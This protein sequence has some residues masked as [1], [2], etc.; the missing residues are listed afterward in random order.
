MNLRS[1]NRRLLLP[2]LV[3][4]Q[5]PRFHIPRHPQFPRPTLHIVIVQAIRSQSQR[6]SGQKLPHPGPGFRECRLHHSRGRVPDLVTAGRI[7]SPRHLRPEARAGRVLRQ[8][9][10]HRT[11]AAAPRLQ[12]RDGDR[13]H[14]RDGQRQLRSRSGR[15]HAGHWNAWTRVMGN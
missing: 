9:R 3:R 7:P 1:V 8:H 11:C 2:A 15:R 14:G 4:V 13:R 10:A 12:H 6:L 5:L